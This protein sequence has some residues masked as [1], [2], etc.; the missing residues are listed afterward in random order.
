MTTPTI[1]LELLKTYDPKYKTW[2]NNELR[3]FCPL[4]SCPSQ[5]KKRDDAHRTF[6]LNELSG[7]YHCFACKI[8]GNY[9]RNLQ[10]QGVPLQID[11]DKIRRERAEADRKQLD[12]FNREW[13]SVRPIQSQWA[14]DYL[15]T[16]RRLDP[17]FVR[18]QNIF[19]CPDYAIYGAQAVIFPIC[20]FHGALTAMQ[21]RYLEEQSNGMTVRTLRKTEMGLYR[22]RGAAQSKYLTITEAPIDS[23]SLAFVGVPSVAV[24]GS[25]FPIG[26]LLRMA[27]DKTVIIASDYDKGG[28]EAAA[29]WAAEFDLMDIANYRLSPE[30]CKDWNEFLK[31]YGRQELHQLVRR[32]WLEL[33]NN[34]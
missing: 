11:W 20:N 8:K 34:G 29:K 2:N 9:L 12:K 18:S 16:E 17:D 23:L 7:V 30:P 26:L 19:E 4:P 27:L 3:F 22:T 33:K 6:A 31:R 14:F 15:E 32:Q 28:D 13:R 24:C 10:S 25:S 5:G 1:T 21:G